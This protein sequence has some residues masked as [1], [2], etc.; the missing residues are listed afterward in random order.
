MADL[1][2]R[3]WSFHTVD[4]ALEDVV[5]FANTFKLPS[6]AGA[7][8]KLKSPDALQASKTPWVFI[9]GSYPGM[10]AGMLRVRNPET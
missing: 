3:Q 4:Q 2:G 1:D 8:S 5:V 9:G 6:K 7:A 10:R